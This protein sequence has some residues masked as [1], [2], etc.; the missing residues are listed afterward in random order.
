MSV[1]ADEGQ[2]M[3]RL[4]RME[5]PIEPEDVATALS[6]A[7]LEKKAFDL[8][9]LDMRGLVDYCDLFVICSARNRRQVQA[10]AE[11]VRSHGK[12]ELRLKPQAI[13]GLEA[14]RWV[15][16]DFGDVVLHV[17]DEPMRGFYNLDGLW[18]DAPR[19]EAPEG[20]GKAVPFEDDHDDDLPQIG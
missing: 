7:A 17:F 18:S 1:A 11:F 15:L 14:A 5:G 4:P 9:I 2:D 16:V 10:I 20:G 13:E 6:K 12:R 3:D 8:A 19:L